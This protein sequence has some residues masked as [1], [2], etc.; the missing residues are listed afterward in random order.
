VSDDSYPIC[1]WC[2]KRLREVQGEDGSGFMYCPMHGVI[3]RRSVQEYRK[4]AERAPGRSA[5]E[6]LVPEVKSC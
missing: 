1:P 3:P 4:W 5:Y 2:H 6:V